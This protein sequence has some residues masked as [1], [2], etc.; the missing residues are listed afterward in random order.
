MLPLKLSKKKKKKKMTALHALCDNFKKHLKITNFV[1]T[2]SRTEKSFNIKVYCKED[3][4]NIKEKLDH[5]NMLFCDFNFKSMGY[6]PFEVEEAISVR[7]DYFS[8]FYFYSRK[9]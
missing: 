5:L 6:C 1:L 7:R 4:T 2:K 3:D 8:T 9:K